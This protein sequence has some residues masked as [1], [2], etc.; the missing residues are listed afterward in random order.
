LEDRRLLALEGRIDAELEL[1]RVSELVGELEGLVSDHPFRERLLG[2]LMLAL[3][4]AGRQ[5][6]A[7][8]A[9][10]AA[11]RRFASELG[12]EPGPQLAQLERQILEHD[13]S[14]SVE[15]GIRP[16]VRRRRVWL[17]AAAAAVGVAAVAGG[18][19]AFAPSPRPAGVNVRGAHSA[20]LVRLEARSGA[21]HPAPDLP[22]APASIAVGNGSL[23]ISDTVDNELLRADS[24][25]GA[26][27]DRIPL[28]Q[29]PGDV[30]AGEGAVRLASAAGPSITCVDATT[31]EILQVI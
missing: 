15:R 25:S 17:L 30:A 18:V 3:Y 9:F 24:R 27:N 6:A 14:L 20:R 1:G 4:R 19:A 12:I 23:W 11:R 7:L 13:P 10:R 8:E 26:V 29:Q 22:G 21:A 5:A 31:D 16:S 2:Q 28:R